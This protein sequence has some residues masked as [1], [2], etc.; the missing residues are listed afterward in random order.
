MVLL[1]A[2]VSVS[3]PFSFGFG[4]VSTIEAM[5]NVCDAFFLFDIVLNFRTSYIDSD[6][7]LVLSGKRITKHYLKT[8]FTLD[9]VSSMPWDSVSAGLLPGLQAARVLKIGKIAKVLK[10]LRIGKA[11]KT[12]AGSSLIERIE[13]SL[14]PKAHQTGSKLV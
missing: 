1:L 14:P 9:L 5:D 4:T 6:E 2:Y 13:E 3:L 11:I 7:C 8:W 10:L 12:L